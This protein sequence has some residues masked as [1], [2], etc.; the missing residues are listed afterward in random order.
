MKVLSKGTYVGIKDNNG[1]PVRIGNTVIDCNTNIQYVIEYDVD[2]LAII[3]RSGMTK[4][5]LNKL[6]N[7]L[8]VINYGN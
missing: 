8:K 6:K 4:T 3:G 2:S 1:K 5:Q 7:N